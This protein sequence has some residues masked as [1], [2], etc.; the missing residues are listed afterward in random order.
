MSHR[1]LFDLFFRQRVDERRRFTSIGSIV[2]EVIA[3]R[4]NRNRLA[5][6]VVCAA[7]GLTIEISIDETHAY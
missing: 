1:W 5:N 3:A 2:V 4:Q 7:Q 6:I